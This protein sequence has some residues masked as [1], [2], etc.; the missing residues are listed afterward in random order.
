LQTAA[1][2]YAARAEQVQLPPQ[3]ALLANFASLEASLEM[4]QVNAVPARSTCMQSMLVPTS[5]RAA[6]VSCKGCLQRSAHWSRPCRGSRLSKATRSQQ[7]WQGLRS[8]HRQQA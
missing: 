7:Q 3:A 6:R 5:V 1:A 4:Q 2:V 8:R